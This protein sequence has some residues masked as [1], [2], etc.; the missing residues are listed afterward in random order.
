MKAEHLLRMIVTVGVFQIWSQTPEYADAINPQDL[1]EIKTVGIFANVRGDKPLIGSAGVNNLIAEYLRL[2]DYDSI[3][4]RLPRRAKKKIIIKAAERK[5]LDAILMFS[6]T[7]KEKTP[8]ASRHV[9]AEYSLVAVLSG[10]S[11]MKG[12]VVEVVYDFLNLR[13]IQEVISTALKKLPDC[14]VADEI[15]VDEDSSATTSIKERILIKVVTDQYYRENDAWQE[16]IK[17]KFKYVS[18]IYEKQFDV[19]LV[20]NE[21]GEWNQPE[22]HVSLV[23]LLEDFVAVIPLEEKNDVVVG[24][25]GQTEEISEPVGVTHFLGNH[26]LVMDL[27]TVTTAKEWD[28]VNEGL[29]LAHE[30]G[31]IFGAMHMASSNS[32][33]H[34]SLSGIHT[35]S[36]SRYNLKIMNFVLKRSSDSPK[37]DFDAFIDFIMKEKDPEDIDVLLQICFRLWYLERQSSIIDVCKR[38]STLDPDL[39]EMH[40][41]LGLVYEDQGKYDEAIEAYRKGVKLQPE[42]EPKLIVQQ[43][44]PSSVE[45]D[46]P[47]SQLFFRA[48]WRLGVLLARQGAFDESIQVLGNIKKVPMSPG[49]ASALRR[50]I[51]VIENARDQGLT[52]DD[53]YL[54]GQ[55]GIELEKAQTAL[56]NALQEEEITREDSKEKVAELDSLYR[57]LYKLFPWLRSYGEFNAEK[58]VPE[59]GASDFGVRMAKGRLL[60]A[61][62][63]LGMA[64]ANT[65]SFEKAL[66][67]FDEIAHNISYPSY[68]YFMLDELLAVCYKAGEYQ[69]AW[70]YYRVA[71]KLGIPVDP[72]VLRKLRSVST[73]PY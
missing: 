69:I 42:W 8:T 53:P 56:R 59:I 37:F 20:I 15:A 7:Q 4:L 70:K 13:T 3:V 22:R 39:P 32:L 72:I 29:V 6:Y 45:Y 14:P 55:A 9:A 27:P 21:I 71:I 49:L 67:Q 24:F 62:Y 5:S 34:R 65:G 47:R 19:K 41:F 10:K 23:T 33:M 64:Y 35:S 50:E 36:F 16:V 25:I 12:S 68:I 17:E 54:L 31:H 60:L 52:Y 58:A 66:R 57:K 51:A 73:R 1:Q 48:N 38:A 30:L 18:T 46:F 61:R 11:I 2:K 28:V 40:I 44:I 26:L 63:R 43:S